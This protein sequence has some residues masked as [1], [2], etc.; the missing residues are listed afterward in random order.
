MKAME[1]ALAQQDCS[2][3]IAITLIDPK[4]GYQAV[5]EAMGGS[6][7]TA[8]LLSSSRNQLLQLQNPLF[9]CLAAKTYG[10]AHPHNW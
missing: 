1:L 5:P 3:N 9:N 6:L 2:C 10:G 7:S 8:H 4:I